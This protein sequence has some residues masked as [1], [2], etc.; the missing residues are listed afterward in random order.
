MA[1]VVP[2][3]ALLRAS[4][5]HLDRMKNNEDQSL[6]ECYPLSRLDTDTEQKISAQDSH[7]SNPPGPNGEED[8]QSV[9]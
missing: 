7:K 5:S 2:L 8:D 6:A 3:F 9:Y 4:L 1:T